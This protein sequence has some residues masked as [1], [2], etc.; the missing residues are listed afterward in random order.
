MFLV[1]NLFIS[2]KDIKILFKSLD[3]KRKEEIKNLFNFNTNYFEEAYKKNKSVRVIVGTN[4]LVERNL[5]EY[6]VTTKL[7]YKDDDYIY[8]YKAHPET[9][10]ENDETKIEDLKKINITP[11]DSNVPFEMII[12]YNPNISCSGYYSSAFI[13]IGEKNL[14]ALFEQY[15]K[16]DEYYNKFDY[17]CQYIKKMK[18]NMANI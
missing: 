12:Y 3:D 5:Y 2:T 14:K 16:E 13:D 8:Y 10:I 9:P 18:K 4:G 1:N 15:K 7:F 6:C 17:F 11:V